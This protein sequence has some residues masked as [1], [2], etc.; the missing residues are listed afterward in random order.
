MAAPLRFSVVVPSYRRPE[1]LRRCLRGLAAQ[2]VQADEI[3][4]VRRL[5]DRETAK[6]ITEFEPSVAD[7]TVMRP[8]L[9]AAL[10]AGAANATGDIIAFTDDDAVP[11]PDWIR[12]LAGTFSDPTVG[13]VGGRDCIYPRTAETAPLPVEVGRL[14]RWG[15]VIGNHHIGAGDAR[16][17]DV[18]KGVNMAFRRQALAL[19]SD[20][21][22]IGA[23][24]HSDL[25]ITLWAGRLGWR[26][27][28]DPAILVDHYPALR[29]SGDLRVTPPQGVLRD[30][31]YNYVAAIL[32][33]K[34][35]LRWRLL[36][37]VTI[38][39]SRSYPGLTRTLAAFAA[40]DREIVRRF[41]PS[42]AGQIQAI[43]DFGRTR[44]VKMV[45][46]DQ[47]GADCISVHSSGRLV[48]R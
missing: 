17:V 48:K 33:A 16:D 8:G 37:Y 44:A 38:V 4:V 25:A 11:C 39:G 27:I 7:V 15:R 22:G 12:R 41:L 29:P 40:G 28:Y 32:A 34:P 24:C 30:N 13:G 43:A 18:L 10:T 36:G 46:L 42:V 35:Q 23:Q 31:A 3:I 21:R 9:V 6:V 5:E 1:E 26:I 45:P 2:I 20:L 19:P 14:T 47:V